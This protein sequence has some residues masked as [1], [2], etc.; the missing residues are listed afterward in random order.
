MAEG[1]DLKGKV[2]LVT[3]CNTG[4]G[5]ETA[6][7]LAAQGATVFLACRSLDKA[8]ATMEEIKQHN[9]AADLHALECDLSSLDSVA[10]AAEEF[11][12]QSSKLH[13]L[14]NNAG[15]MMIPEF[16]LTKDGYEMQWGTN[17]LGHFL[18]THKLLPALQQAAPSRVVN[19]SSMAHQMAPSYTADIVPPQQQT[20][21]G[22]SNYGLSKLSNILFS[23]EFN[24]RHGSS[25]VTSFALH[26]GV[27]PTDLG[28]YS[29]MANVFYKIGTPFMKNIP[30]G[31]ATQVYCALRA[32]PKDCLAWFSDCATSTKFTRDSQSDAHAQH[33]WGVSEQAAQKWM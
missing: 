9:A 20:Y 11:L 3:G 1:V 13:L 12:K 19:V 5:K 4:I 14:I 27:I 22:T 16:T 7:V 21:N 18:L 33:L 8:Q 29:T 6:R 17:H 10:K 25:G 30:Q 15:V 24:R 2:A 31:A 32:D 28:R 23:R 26:P